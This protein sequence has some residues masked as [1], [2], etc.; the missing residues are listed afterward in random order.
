MT[1]KKKKEKVHLLVKGFNYTH[2]EKYVDALAEY[3][4]AYKIDPKDERLLFEIAYVYSVLNNYEKAKLFYGK[5]LKRDE[6]NADA[7]LNLSILYYNN[8]ETDLALETLGTISKDHY[9]EKYYEIFF[10]IFFKQKEYE[11]A[12]LVSKKI[13][14]EKYSDHSYLEKYLIVITTVDRSREVFPILYDVYEANKKYY[15]DPLKLVEYSKFILFYYKNYEKSYALL[16]RSLDIRKT[17]EAY[18]ELAK[19]YLIE[20]KYKKSRLYLDMISE[21]YSYNKE[22]RDLKEILEEEGYYEK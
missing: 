11:K 2:Q 8:G 9:T 13:Y 7:L 15:N 21:K 18:L 20:K 22:A 10:D 3:L 14:F 5:I 4:K 16:K 17:D 19:L 6:G 1:A 12:L